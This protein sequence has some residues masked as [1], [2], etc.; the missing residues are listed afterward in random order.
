MK[1][2]MALFERIQ[3][4][5]KETGLSHTCSRCGR[6]LT[7]IASIRRGIGPVCRKLQQGWDVVEL[8]LPVHW[9]TYLFYGDESGLE[10]NEKEMIDAHLDKEE[11]GECADWKPEEAYFTWASPVAAYGG[12][13]HCTYVFIKYH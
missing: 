13:D 2:N 4:I 12:G 9:A 3:E 11:V 8:E 1:L 5:W 10:E 6:P 7:D